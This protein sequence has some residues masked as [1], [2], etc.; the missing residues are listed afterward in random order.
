MKYTVISNKFHGESVLSTHRSFRAAL[1][2]LVK[3]DCISCT[4]GGPRIAE[5]SGSYLTAISYYRSQ[6]RMTLTDAI[7]AVA[8][9]KKSGRKAL[10]HGQY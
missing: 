5:D 1:S 6:D 8:S 10:S 2:S 3:H 9:D 4:C 7:I